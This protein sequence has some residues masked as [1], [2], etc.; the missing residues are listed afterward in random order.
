[1]KL[2]KLFAYFVVSPNFFLCSFILSFILY[3]LFKFILLLKFT[4][5]V[6]FVV[7]LSQIELYFS[8]FSLFLFHIVVNFPLLHSLYHIDLTCFFPSFFFTHILLVIL[9][10]SNFLTVFYLFFFFLLY[11]TLS[12]SFYIVLLVFSPSH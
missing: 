12:K 11:L 3:F 10:H 7:S 1:M 9:L 2:I 4:Y 8:S 6:F 5:L